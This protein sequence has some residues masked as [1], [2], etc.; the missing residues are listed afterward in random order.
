LKREGIVM[1]T[2]C[3]G[4][5]KTAFFERAEVNL[6]KPWARLAE[7]AEPEEVAQFALKS[8][9]KSKR[10]KVHGLR[11]SMFVQLLRFLSKAQVMKLVWR[12]CR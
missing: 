2:I 12:N 7:W 1:T 6:D 8:L 10:I 4:A 9:A 11:N 3:P 5:T